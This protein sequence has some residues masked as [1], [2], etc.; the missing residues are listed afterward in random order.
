M[1]A[2]LSLLIFLNSVLI[3]ISTARILDNFVSKDKD[4]AWIVKQVNIKSAIKN[5]HS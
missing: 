3:F 2:A 5:N 1:I 4:F